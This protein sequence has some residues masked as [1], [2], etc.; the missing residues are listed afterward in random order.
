MSEYLIRPLKDFEY[1][2]WDKFVSQSPQGTLFH[3]VSWL[4]ASGEKFKIYGCFSGEELIAGLSLIYKSRWGLRIATHPPL[5]PYLGILF[6]KSEAK[7]V[8]RLSREKKISRY[9]AKRVKEDFDYVNIGFSH[10]L[11]DLQ[12]FIWEGFSVS[13]R[14]TYLLKLDNIE[15]VWSGMDETR[16]KNIRRAEKDGIYVES[17]SGFEELFALVEKTF[18]RQKMK[19]R[20]RSVAFRY[21]ETLEKQGRCRSFVARNKKGNPIAGVYIVWDWNR[22]YYLLGG[23][24]P[25]QSHH[26]ASA[27]AMW[28]AIK[29]TK[30]GLGLN[31][32]DFEGSMIQPVE[33]FFRKFGGILTP[34]YTAIWT[35]PLLKPF[36]YGR[37]AI[38]K[39]KITLRK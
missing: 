16:R 38:L 15:D 3:T 7:Y 20:F 31:E 9:L 33:Q 23:Y 22:S 21:N 39:S 1:A 27:L 34:C 10:S 17:D 37:Q 2:D 30:E 5:T 8:N 19:T 12:P 14:Y 25:E 36:I 26:G 28:E 24:D 18:K 6:R 13:I 32:F 35:K 4:T 11:V 29:F